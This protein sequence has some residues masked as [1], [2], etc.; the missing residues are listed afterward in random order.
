[1]SKQKTVNK[2][3]QYHTTEFKLSAVKIAPEEHIEAT[4]PAGRLVLTLKT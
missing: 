3:G 2:K 4:E 1:M